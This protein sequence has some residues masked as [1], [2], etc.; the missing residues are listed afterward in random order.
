MQLLKKI[1]F[2]LLLL[3]IFFCLHGSLENYGFVELQEILVLGGLILACLGIGLVLTWLFTRN[4]LM[5]ALICFFI[6]LWYLF[7]GAIYDWLQTSQVLHFLH[8]YQVLIPALIVLTVGWIIFLHKKRSKHATLSMYLNLLLLLYCGIDSFLLI[9]K[10]VEPVRKG[11]A[12]AVAFDPGKVTQKPN[13]YYLLFDE[14]AGYQSLKDSFGF[15]NDSL[16][17]FLDQKGFRNIPGGSNYDFTLFSMSSI[18]NMQYVDTTGITGTTLQNDLQVRTNEIRY[19]SV[20]GLFENMGYQIENYSIFDIGNRH[21]VSDKNDFLPVHS[22]LLT[23]KIFHNRLL[24][25]SGWIFKTGKFALPAWKK[26]YLY[27]HDVTNI[28]SEQAVK[29]TAADKSTVPKFCYAHFIIPHGPFYRDSSGQYNSDASI[30]D[31]ATL[32]NK[33]AYLAYLKYGNTVIE[34]LVESITA[35][36]PQAIIVLMSDHGFRPY[37]TPERYVPFCF[38]NICAV[39]FPNNNYGATGERHS[40]V[41]FFRYLFNKQFGQNIPYLPDRV[42]I[43]Y[44]RNVEVK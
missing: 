25:T 19:G 16:Y 9:T 5:S 8:R 2:F 24:R 44:D 3:V 27:Q 43:V 15:A 33:A 17:H 35:N 38:D 6:A 26:K 28:F 11:Q 23:D 18:F 22:R 7:F 30:A 42:S 29:Q 13:V 20:F 41:N 39:R 10:N 12:A 21:S 32:T 31:E 1:P 34:S 36:D 14:Y 40:A 37:Q 4:W